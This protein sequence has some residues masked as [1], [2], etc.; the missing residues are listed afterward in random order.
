MRVEV[1]YS[2]KLTA[3]QLAFGKACVELGLSKTP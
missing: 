2:E 1:L 3:L